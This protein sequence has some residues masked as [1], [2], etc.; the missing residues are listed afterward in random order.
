[1]RPARPERLGDVLP[2]LRALEVGDP[3]RRELLL[4]GADDRPVDLVPRPRRQRRDLAL[5]PVHHRL[6]SRSEP[7]LG[8]PVAPPFAPAASARCSSWT[9]APLRKRYVRRCASKMGSRRRIHSSSIAACSFSSSPLCCRI[10]RSS[11]SCVAS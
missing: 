10:A 4:R 2:P 7:T 5:E 8:R 11:P 3:P 6:P 1:R 9:I